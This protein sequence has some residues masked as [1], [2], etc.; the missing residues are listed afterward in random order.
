MAVD[1]VSV[2]VMIP[3][4]GVIVMLL[5]PTSQ[6]VPVPVSVHVPEPGLMPRAVDDDP[7][8]S[9]ASV[10]LYPAASN[11]PRSIERFLPVSVRS[12]PRETVPPAPTPML[13]VVIAA[14]AV[15]VTLVRPY[16]LRDPGLAE[17]V[18][19]AANVKLPYR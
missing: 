15:R 18:I 5:P 13:K 11:V 2:I 10:T 3:L 4:L 12:F 1:D 6:T 14:K 7:F 17:V 16:I 9:T 19:P 8:V